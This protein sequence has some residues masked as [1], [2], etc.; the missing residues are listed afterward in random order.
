M[1]GGPG[2]LGNLGPFGSQLVLKE[3]INP[4]FSLKILYITLV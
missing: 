2:T 3:C 4:G 1:S